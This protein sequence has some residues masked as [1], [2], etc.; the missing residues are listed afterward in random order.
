MSAGVGLQGREAAASF[1][2]PPEANSS[3]PERNRTAR[4]TGNDLPPLVLRFINTVSHRERR[5]AAPARRATEDGGG[6]SFFSRCIHQ[7]CPP[8]KKRNEAGARGTAQAG[9]GAGAQRVRGQT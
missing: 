3:I 9:S 6:H 5:C 8:R 2:S 4:A 7:E 1:P